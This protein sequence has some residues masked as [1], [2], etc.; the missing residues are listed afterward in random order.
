VL[1]L[2]EAV[3]TLEDA[4]ARELYRLI[5]D[6]L[7]ATIVI[8]A[9]RSAARVGGH[10]RTIELTGAAK[11]NVGRARPALAAVPA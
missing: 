5:A 9:G 8:S 2:D 1:L 6:K 7:P 10:Q 4:E 11:N 3:S